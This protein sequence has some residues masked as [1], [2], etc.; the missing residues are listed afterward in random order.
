MLCQNVN[1]EKQVRVNIYH[2]LNQSSNLYDLFNKFI[3]K[4]K[5]RKNVDYSKHQIFNKKLLK[6]INDLLIYKIKSK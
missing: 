6:I 5:R 1:V 2:C 4:K 3:L